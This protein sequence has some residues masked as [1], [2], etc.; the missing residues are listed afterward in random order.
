MNKKFISILITGLFAAGVGL[1]VQQPTIKASN[2]KSTDQYALNDDFNWTHYFY[3]KNTVGKHNAYIWNLGHTKRIHNLNNYK[4]TD[5]YVYSFY[6][7]KKNGK[8]YKYY[9]I[10]NYNK[11]IVG[12]VYSK[13]LTIAANKPL[14]SF[15]SDSEYLNYI[16]TAQSQK[17]AR[18][19]LK[20]FPNIPLSL[21]ATKFITSPAA[22]NINGNSKFK[23]VIN[24]SNNISGTVNILGTVQNRLNYFKQQLNKTSYSKSQL[25]SLS[26][27][28]L[29][30]SIYDTSLDSYGS[31]VA[32]IHVAL[33]KK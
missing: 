12:V 4:N 31:Q 20:L 10:R 22:E 18:G 3:N 2:N 23:H 17:L 7:T 24:L 30:L 28:K 21:E 19:I 11:S 5:W 25:N 15:N 8:K 27:Y 33:V 9:K 14:T 1:A 26:G 6:N 16:Q 13:F 32:S 29:A